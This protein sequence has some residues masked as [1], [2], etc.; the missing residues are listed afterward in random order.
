[1]TARGDHRGALIL[2]GEV[3]GCLYYF[4]FESYYLAGGAAIHWSTQG[5]EELNDAC[6]SV[7]ACRLVL[8]S[9]RCQG[10]VNGLSAISGAQLVYPNEH[11]SNST[12]ANCKE[13]ICLLTPVQSEKSQGI[14]IYMRTMLLILVQWAISGDAYMPACTNTNNNQTLMALLKSSDPHCWAEIIFCLSENFFVLVIGACRA[15]K[16]CPVSWSTYFDICT[17]KWFQ[18]FPWK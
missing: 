10:G 15:A 17:R 8:L 4:C 18:L 1:M 7:C 14:W 2:S 11:N 6:E 9:A 16:C 5:T 13:G 3:V 12:P